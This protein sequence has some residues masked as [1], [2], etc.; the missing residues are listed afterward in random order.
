MLFHEI[1]DDRKT[2]VINRMM[3]SVK[4]GGKV[5]CIE[6]HMPY[7]WRYFYLYYFSS[8][9]SIYILLCK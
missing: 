5:I 6:Y 2:K 8:F 1:T 4:P 3:K 7:K 9:S